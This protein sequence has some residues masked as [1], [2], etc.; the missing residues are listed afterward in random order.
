MQEWEDKKK[1]TEGWC[2]GYNQETH[3]VG[4]EDL[5]MDHVYPVSKAKKHFEKTG[6]KIVYTINDIEPICGPCNSSKYNNLEAI[7]NEKK[8]HTKTQKK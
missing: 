8:C 3:Y 7:V 6:V 4:L 1:S 5:T 2:E